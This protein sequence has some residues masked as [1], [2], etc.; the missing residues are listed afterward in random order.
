MSQ[1]DTTDGFE[2]RLDELTQILPDFSGN[3]I[4]RVESELGYPTNETESIQ[5]PAKGD[6]VRY[7]NIVFTINSVTRDN[8]SE[9]FLIP[10][11]VILFC[12]VGFEK[13]PTT[14]R[15]HVQGYC[16]FNRQVEFSH[17][18]KWLPHAWIAR[19]RGNQEQNIAYCS[20]SEDFEEYGIRGTKKPGARTDLDRVIDI[21]NNNPQCPMRAMIREGYVSGQQQRAAEFILKYSMQVRTEPPELIWITGPSGVGKS[22]MAWQ[23]CGY[24]NTYVKNSLSKWFD[25]YDGH[26]NLI[27]DDM[28][29]LTDRDDIVVMFLLALFDVNPIRVETK[30]SSRQFMS[31]RIV[32]TSIY[33]PC[34]ILRNFVGE[35]PFQVVRR[36]SRII[37]LTKK[38]QTELNREQ[39]ID[40]YCTRTMFNESI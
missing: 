40:E 38:G 24:E 4:Q 25:G 8:F 39:L 19:S 31:S 18:R 12:I 27:L 1:V 20:K 17:L 33:E 6:R 28:K 32:I 26:E 21:I 9:N 10:S 35:D 16:E 29:P 13:A 34:Q 36:V 14:G 22:R 15:Q 11:E 3:Q 2:L 37:R 23:I 7:R 30:G 5:K